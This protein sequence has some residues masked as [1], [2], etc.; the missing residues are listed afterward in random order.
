MASKLVQASNIFLR[1]P[2][3]MQNFQKSIC[4]M[5]CSPRQS[6]FLDAEVKTVYPDDDEGEYKIEIDILGGYLP[7]SQA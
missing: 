4:A 7:K 1:C 5:N 3:C 2:T 6:E